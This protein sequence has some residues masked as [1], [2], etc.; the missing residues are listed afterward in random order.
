MFTSIEPQ[1][2]L[3]WP[4]LSDLLVGAASVIAIIVVA[5]ALQGFVFLAPWLIVIPLAMFLAGILSGL[6]FGNRLMK[7]VVV[8]LPTIML[9]LS[10]GR[11]VGVVAMAGATIL[12]TLVGI[13]A[14]RRYMNPA[15]S[16]A[17]R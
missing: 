4:L 6:S 13:S 16:D 15:R 7:A 10:W 14:R 11:G 9:M 8:N 3:W 12:C 2:Y 1:R 17:V 5:L